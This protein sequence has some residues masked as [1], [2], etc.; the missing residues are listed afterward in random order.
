MI[1]LSLAWHSKIYLNCAGCD[2]AQAHLC[3]CRTKTGTPAVGCVT[4]VNTRHCLQ[5]SL[6]LRDGCFGAGI[7]MRIYAL[8]VDNDSSSESDETASAS[9]PGTQLAGDR[10]PNTSDKPDAE[11][12]RP[13]ANATVLPGSAAAQEPLH[14]SSS[15]PTG[16]MPLLLIEFVTLPWLCCTS[17]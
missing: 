6:S 4:Y 3:P 17:H 9:D 16:Y 12:L 10:P 8:C 13:P 2:R 14:A 1:H 5:T 11:D 7:L 15:Q